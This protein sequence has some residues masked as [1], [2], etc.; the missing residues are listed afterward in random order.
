MGDQQK[1]LNPFKFRIWIVEWEILCIEKTDKI[2]MKTPFLFLD[3]AVLRFNLILSNFCCRWWCLFWVK[4]FHGWL[5]QLRSM[6]ENLLSRIYLYMWAMGQWKKKNRNT[7]KTFTWERL[8][9]DSRQFIYP[10]VPT[11]RPFI[12]HL[13]FILFLFLS[14][15]FFLTFLFLFVEAFSSSPSSFGF[16]CL[17]YKVVQPSATTVAASNNEELLLGPGRTLLFHMLAA[18]DRSDDDGI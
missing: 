10:V 1:T 8:E 14:F 11:R 12:F 5:F 17:V 2:P 7:T 3:P 9:A 13:F 6:I 16:L 4:F 15:F 18:L